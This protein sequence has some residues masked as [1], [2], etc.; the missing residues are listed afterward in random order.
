MKVINA[1]NLILE[2]AVFN[3][4]EIEKRMND[5]NFNSL[6]KFELFIWDLEMFLQLQQ[7]LGDSIILKG[8]AAA[9]FYIPPT[10]QRTSVDIDMICLTSREAVHKAISE[11]ELEFNS[12]YEYF[13]FRY[14]EPKNPKV[15]LNNLETYY[16]TVPSICL[17]DELFATRGKQEV[18]IEFLYMD[19]A[20]EINKYS[21]PDLFALETDKEFNILSLTELFADKLTTL[22]PNTI[23]ISDERADE[24]FKQIYD[25]I[26]LFL[27]NIDQIINDKDLIKQKYK[28]VAKLE[29]EMHSVKY[30]PA[31][32][33]NDMNIII[34]RLKNIEGDQ[35]L[36]QIANDFQS[37]Y[38]RRIVNRNKA[39][40]SIV[41]YQLHYLIEYIF[42]DDARIQQYRSIKELI[43]HLNFE[44]LSG[45]ERGEVQREKREV[46]QGKFGSIKGLSED[47]FRKRFDRIIWE[48]IGY[49]SIDDIEAVLK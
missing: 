23:G 18:K 37:L 33:Y 25:V 10:S 8:G 1:D 43:N 31:D 15:S 46:M 44:N 28:K 9:Q 5:G 11:I 45:P 32:L 39:E 14:Y 6:S 36:Q 20:Y 35:R 17:P 27:S 4:S 3:R 2:K 49:V 40:W 16:V 12:K 24:Q 34:N 47:L 26:T 48:L 13:K 38:L 42:K 29:C 30:E 7:K 19:S 41:G 21:R 22:G